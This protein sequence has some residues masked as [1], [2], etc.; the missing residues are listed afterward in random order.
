MRPRLNGD[1]VWKGTH[2]TEAGKIA[3]GGYKDGIIINPSGSRNKYGLPDNMKS[4]SGSGIK[5]VPLTPTHN[6]L[7]VKKNYSG[8]IPTEVLNQNPHLDP[9]KAK[10]YLKLKRLAAKLEKAHYEPEGELVEKKKISG[11]AIFPFKANV[12]IKNEIISDDGI[13][14]KNPVKKVKGLEKFDEAKMTEDEKEK[15][16]DIVKGMKKDKKGFKKRYGKDAESVMYATATKLAMEEKHKD[17]EPEMIRNQLKTAKRASKRIK[18]HTLKKD[19]FKAW[20][21]SKI[22]KATDYLD[23]A[24][25]YLD[26]KDDMK[27]E[28]DKKDLSLIHI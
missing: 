19:N 15:K 26:S 25:D 20:V 28:L 3:F 27:E 7:L 8:K 6:R 23:T 13:S 16:E 22:T 12:K 11:N 24:A 18:S 14:T 9:L 5:E 4:E 21:Q 17:H 2:I 10:D 1:G